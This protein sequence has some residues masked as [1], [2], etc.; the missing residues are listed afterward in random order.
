MGNKVISTE[1]GEVNKI[2]FWDI[3]TNYEPSNL[4]IPIVNNNSLW[5]LHEDIT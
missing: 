4:T 3:L 5:K 1:R 2:M